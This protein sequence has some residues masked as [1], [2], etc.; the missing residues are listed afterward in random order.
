MVLKYQAGDGVGRKEA[1]GNMDAFLANPNDWLFQKNAEKKGA[2]KYDYA[3]ANTDPQ[4]VILTSIWAAIV[5]SFIGRVIYVYFDTKGALVNENL[6][7]ISDAVT[8][9]L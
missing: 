1:Q 5:F 7:A 8:S 9:A 4:Q 2:A 3:N 6:S